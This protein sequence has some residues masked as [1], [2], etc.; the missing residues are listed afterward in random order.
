MND[1]RAL[2]G[3][4]GL[5]THEGFHTGGAG[6]DHDGGGI[7]FLEEGH[8]RFD[9]SGCTHQI[10]I[11]TGLPAFLAHVAAASTNIG[12]KDINASEFFPG[13]G[14]PGLVALLIGNIYHRTGDLYALGAQFGNAGIHFF[15]VAGTD[16]EIYPFVCQQVGNGA[17]DAAG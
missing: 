9:A 5:G 17:T 8:C 3:V 16:G 2:D 6:N 12:D 11:E 4:V 7:G 10:H 14:N 15:L 13:T 1:Q